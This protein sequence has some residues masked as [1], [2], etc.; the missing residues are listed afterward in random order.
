ML[1]FSTICFGPIC[2]DS[3]Y[4]ISKLFPVSDCLVEEKSGYAKEN[5]LLYCINMSVHFQFTLKSFIMNLQI[6]DQL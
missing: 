4:P 2:Y 5:D 1:T 6:V 3:N